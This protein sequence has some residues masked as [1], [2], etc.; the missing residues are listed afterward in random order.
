M[1]DHPLKRVYEA[2]DYRVGDRFVIR[3][4]ERSPPLDDLLVRHDLETWAYLTAHNPGSRRLDPDDNRRRQAALV[5]RVAALGLPSFAGEG[6][7]DP[8]EW[9]AEPSL[10]VL[11]I[12]LATA[13]ALGREFGQVAILAGRRGEPA[14]LSFCQSPPGG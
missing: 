10:L 11:G 7:G 2:T 4:G 13:L 8:R 5:D 6:V 3:C 1:T 9:P 14:G 12:D